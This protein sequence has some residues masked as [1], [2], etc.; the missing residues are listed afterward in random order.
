MT[1][2]YNKIVDEQGNNRER[3]RDKDKGRNTKVD[4][5]KS[6]VICSEG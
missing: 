4:L 6:I 3:S 2:D 5:D 1:K